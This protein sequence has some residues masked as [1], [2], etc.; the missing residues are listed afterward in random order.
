MI[1]KH[2]TRGAPR[3]TDTIDIRKLENE[4]RRYLLFV[5][6]VAVLFHG[7][8]GLY[9]GFETARIQQKPVRPILRNNP[10]S[11]KICVNMIVYALSSG[12]I[13]QKMIDSSSN[14]IQNSRQWWD[15]QT[16]KNGG[17]S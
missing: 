13:A 12:S 6:F 5:F 10:Y 7:V 17:K 4:S 14:P 15:Y 8:V 1:T 2:N 3:I 9:V 16:L 11:M